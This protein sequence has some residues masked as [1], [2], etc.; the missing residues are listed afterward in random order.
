[1]NMHGRMTMTFNL[2]SSTSPL[3]VHKSES[4]SSQSACFS[5]S[6]CQISFTKSF[7]ENRI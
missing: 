7:K 2:Y 6:T 3:S 1:M 5:K 4:N